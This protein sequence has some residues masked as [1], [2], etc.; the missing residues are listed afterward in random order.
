M[1]LCIVIPTL[2]E[3][4]S[5]E[6][7]IASARAH[8]D[9]VIVADGGSTDGTLRLA[10]DQGV[11]VVQ[12]PPG[13]GTQIAAGV[14]AATGADAVL[15]L[16]ADTVLPEG[17]RAYVEEALGGG[18]AGGGFAVRF[19]SQKARFRLGE[20]IVNLR[21]RWLGVP[22]GDQAQFARAD[23]IAAMGGYPELPI[24]ED[25][26]F[27]RKLRQVGRI[28]FIESPVETSARRL[29]RRTTRTVAT[30]WLIWAL[31]FLGVS[32]QRLA[33]LYRKVR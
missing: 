16:H 30:N 32:P 6:R 29:E 19:A 23:A 1:R 21:S 12:A 3:E 4:A 17:A 8:A 10:A 18:A 28:A 22:L 27:I 13:R 9:H 15:V 24:L 2:D 33:A 7:A 14:R 31:Y 20:R 25:L 5:L 11:E 26:A